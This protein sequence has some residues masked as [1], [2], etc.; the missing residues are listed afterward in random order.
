VYQRYWVVG[1][2]WQAAAGGVCS[3]N[4][5]LPISMVRVIIGI[6]WTDKTCPAAQC[7]RVATQLFSNVAVEPVFP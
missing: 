7:I 4:S 6:L 5:A 1:K 2:C 3:T